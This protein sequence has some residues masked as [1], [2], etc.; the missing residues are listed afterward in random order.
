[1][2][3]KI[4]LSLFIIAAVGSTAFVATRAQLSDTATLAA[5]TFS[6]GTADLRIAKGGSN[7][8]HAD[9]VTGFSETGVLPGKTI[10]EFFRLRNDSD[11]AVLEIAAQASSVSGALAPSDVT[12]AFTPVDG[13]GNSMGSTTTRTLDIWQSTPTGLGTPN[14]ASGG[15]IQ[16][17]KMDVTVSSSVTTGG[18]SS[19]FDFIF[20]GTQTP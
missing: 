13:S 4:L 8:F 12:V 1:M 15:A 10:T 17:Y 11:D 18:V 2:I 9:S 5:S 14:I 16:R 3:K 20:T 6:V 7:T 19:T